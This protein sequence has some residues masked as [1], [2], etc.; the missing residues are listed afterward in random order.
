M[1]KI[2]KDKWIHF[3]LFLLLALL[4]S[5]SF[6]NIKIVVDV[7]PPIFCALIRVLVSLICLTLIYLSMGKKIL[8]PTWGYWRVWLA[9]LFNQALPFAFLFFGEKFIAPGLASIINS[10]VSIWSLLLGT[11]IFFDFSQWTANKVAGIALGFCGIVL[12]FSPFIHG[13]ENSLLGIFAVTGMAIF[14]A[15]GSLIN[16]HVIFKRMT[17]NFE[18]NLIQQHI[19]S[20]L[21]LVVSSLTLESWPSLMSLL[22]PKLLFSFL[23]LG[24]VATAI[25]WNIYFYLIKKWG[26]VRAT[27]VMYLVPMLAVTWDLLFLHIE[28]SKNELLGMGAI[29]IGVTLIQWTSKKEVF[30]NPST[31]DLDK[32]K[33]LN[34]KS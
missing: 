7:L 20:I 18:T 31:T 3:S 5:G 25:S 2:T 19:S 9:G 11:L 1:K 12:I 14:Y 16:Q 6:I 26:A 28:P 21:F 23:Y 30:S 33:K 27:S 8:A 10:T 29:L 15:I 4:W 34:A 13:N 32:A 22:T 17:V 24:L